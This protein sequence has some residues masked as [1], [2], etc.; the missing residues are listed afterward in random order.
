MRHRERHREQPPRWFTLPC[1]AIFIGMA[2][3]AIGCQCNKE[4]NT[5]EG[6]KVPRN[7]IDGLTVNKMLNGD[8]LYA[9]AE[10][11]S[12]DR[13]GILFLH[14]RA[15]VSGRPPMDTGADRYTKPFLAVC[16]CKEGKYHVI[17]YGVNAFKLNESQSS[18]NKKVTSLVM[19]PMPDKILTD[20]VLFDNKPPEPYK[21]PM[22]L[23][24]KE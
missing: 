1:L 9:Y 5:I 4:N 23:P 22:T 2:I 15:T 12:V 3:L 16:K 19:K 10:D 18:E 21:P 7:N 8:E 17:S 20:K 24:N 14:S 6:A 11:A 13:E